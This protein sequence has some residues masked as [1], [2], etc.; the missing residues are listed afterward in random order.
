MDWMRIIATIFLLA[1][2]LLG[3]YSGIKNDGK[4]RFMIFGGTGYVLDKAPDQK[5][6]VRLKNITLGLLCIILAI[7]F[8]YIQLKTV[9]GR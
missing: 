6:V 8:L 5:T 2:G 9:I 1:W 3:L 4:S 7:G